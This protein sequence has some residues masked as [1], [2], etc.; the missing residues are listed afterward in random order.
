MLGLF[1]GSAGIGGS[2]EAPDTP[3]ADGSTARI[4]R[5]VSTDG[6]RATR[7]PR[8]DPGGGAL[9]QCQR[10]ASAAVVTARASAVGIGAV[11]SVGAGQRREG[12]QLTGR[13]GND[14]QRRRKTMNSS[15]VRPCLLLRAQ[16]AVPWALH[17]ERGAP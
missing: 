6:R 7:G 10:W 12:P 15:P 3:P 5:E 2:V 1:A 4:R 11:P 9:G 16:A 17:G 8:R 14:E 13:M